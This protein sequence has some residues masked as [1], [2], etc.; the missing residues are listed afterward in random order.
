MYSINI[1]GAAHQ[2][3]ERA[4]FYMLR[5]DGQPAIN[6]IHFTSPLFVISDGK[7][8]LAEK[9]SCILYPPKMR[10]EYF[11]NGSTFRNDYLTFSIDEPDFLKKFHLPLGKIFYIKNGEYITEQLEWIAWAAADKTEQHG[12][13]IYLSV[14]KLFEAIEANIIIE[15]PTQNRL[16]STKQRFI[17]IIEEIKK[18]PSGW[19]VNKMAQHAW[20]TRSRFSVVYNDFFGVSPSQDLINIKMNHAKNLLKTTNKPIYIIAK[21]C[22][23]T[24]TQHFI[25]TFTKHTGKTP[26]N[27]RSD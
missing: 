1:F 3:R 22:G 27:Y 2:K 15:T 11:A 8:I 7:K 14:V 19:T 12:M 24:S 21:S 5:E 26:A 25:K 4:D 18:D 9:N 6:F 17:E 10:Q 23:Y 13:D 20:L 16:I